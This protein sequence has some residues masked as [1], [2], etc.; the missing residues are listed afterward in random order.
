[1][2]LAIGRALAPLRKEGV[3]IIGSGQAYHNMRELLGRSGNGIPDSVEFA[4]FLV[5]A[6]KEADAAKRLKLLS[7][8]DQ[9]AAGQVSKRT[10]V[11]SWALLVV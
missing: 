9:L 7:E 6:S 11:R 1:M 8:W 2:H 10:A 3:L 4:D 5:A